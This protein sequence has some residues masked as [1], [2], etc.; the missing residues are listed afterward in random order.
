MWY[1]PY[2]VLVA[3][4]YFLIDFQLLTIQG[5]RTTL[6]QHHN[7]NTLLKLIPPKILQMISYCCK[8]QVKFLA[9]IPHLEKKVFEFD[10]KNFK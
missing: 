9:S 2:L 6:K 7:G 5:L 4:K 10:T 3:V 1:N 8:A